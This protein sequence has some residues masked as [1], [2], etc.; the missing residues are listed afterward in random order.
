MKT[1]IRTF[2]HISFVAC[3]MLLL[4]FVLFSSYEFDTVRGTFTSDF[5]A[6]DAGDSFFETK[7]FNQQLGSSVA[8]V[9]SYCGIMDTL[10]SNEFKESV[11]GNTYFGQNNNNGVYKDHGI[12]EDY[13]NPGTSNVRFFMI[14]KV[15]KQTVSRSNM[16]GIETN[17]DVSSLRKK[18]LDSCDK[19]IYLDG[20]NHIYETNT[21]IEEGTVYK[22]FENSNYAFPVDTTLMVGINRDVS[23]IEDNYS[24]GNTIYKLF[25]DSFVLRLTLMIIFGVLYIAFLV[26]L[27]V[28]DGTSFDKENNKK[29]IKLHVT[30][31]IPCEI[32]LILLIIFAGCLGGLASLIC[33]YELPLQEMYL[34][35]GLGMA[36]LTAV[37][38][39]IVS[40]LFDFFYFGFIRRARARI[41]WKTSFARKLYKWLSSVFGNVYDN[42]G[43]IVKVVLPYV[44][45]CLFN[46]VGAYLATK[47][48]VYFIIVVILILDAIDGYLIFRNYL[49][50]EQIIE[51]IN[52]ICKGDI[53]AKAREDLRGDNKK[54]ADA[55]NQIGNSVN[56]AVNKSMKD[57]KMKADLITNVSHDLKTPLT[58]IIN[59]VDLLKKERIDND[60]A[61]SYIAILDD[62]SQRLK[63]LTD[64]LVEASKISS[65]N[66]VLQME[67]INVK[68][69]LS[70]ASAEFIDKFEEKGLSFVGSAPE[71][72]VMINADSRRIYRVI[73]NLFT[74]I[75][76][77]AMENTRVYLDII[78]DNNKVYIC[79]KNISANPLNMNS[80]ELMER[81]V[82]GDE[83]RNTEGSGLGLSIAK[84]LTEAMGGTFDILLD[85][86][87]FKV[88]ISFE[89]V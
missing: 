2:L 51:V 23:A 24:F 30:D 43:S 57:E 79:V 40:L 32:R 10:D 56:E 21:L 63:Q 33:D 86:D 42:S 88:V 76:K 46:I 78:N 20:I 62:K 38:L 74:N 48:N 68:Q 34:S 72:D 67:K 1:I 39:L 45:L 83:S 73:D 54:L 31:R 12:Y 18:L 7:S 85:G 52:K 77:Y 53:N 25:S 64:D 82:R 55:V 89:A 44:I 22:L 75:Y 69:L 84:N 58:S 36:T 70:Q 15:D 14:E 17:N 47:H 81:F 11:S 61:K 5:Q 3:I 65:G 80:E 49:D 19:Y 9:I 87:L 8:D 50:K 29:I 71:E 59:Y 4:S 27:S 66:I 41:I 6:E 60:N 28:I 13:F 26:V 35:Y 16:P 37:I